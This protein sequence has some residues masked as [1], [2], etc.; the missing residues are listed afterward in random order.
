MSATQT[1][2]PKAKS[3]S[4]KVPAGTISKLAETPKLESAP[5]VVITE[6]QREAERRDHERREDERRTSEAAMA[7]AVQQMSTPVAPQIKTPPALTEA[8]KAEFDALQKKYGVVVV[9]SVPKAASTK[10]QQHGITRPGEG[11]VT[12]KVWTA[13]DRLTTQR[14]N[15]ASIAELKVDASLIGVNDHTIKTQYARWRAFNGVTGRVAKPQEAAKPVVQGAD[16]GLKP[17]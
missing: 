7:F 12:G 3:K 13:A 9:P 6:E 17:M 11:T 16:E 14:G 8:F 4:R 10:V 15:Y 1:E 2:A 5:E